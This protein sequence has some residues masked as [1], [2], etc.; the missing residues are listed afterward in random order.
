MQTKPTII[1]IIGQTPNVSIMKH[2]IFYIFVCVMMSMCVHSLYMFFGFYQFHFH[3]FFFLPRSLIFWLIPY[4]LVLFLYNRSIDS[5]NAFSI[6]HYSKT[7]QKH[8]IARK[9]SQENNFME[10]MCSSMTSMFAGQA[11]VL[12][13]FF[14][15]QMMKTEKNYP[16]FNAIVSKNHLKMPWQV[17]GIVFFFDYDCLCLCAQHSVVNL[18]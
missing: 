9:F 13:Q 8:R 4:H 1:I 2:W 16:R 10:F 12:T 15:Y 7:H 11:L 17:S 18:H 14:I 3:F 5:S 6:K